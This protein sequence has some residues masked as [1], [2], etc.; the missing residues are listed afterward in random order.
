MVSMAAKGA[1]W[2]TVKL[3]GSQKSRHEKTARVSVTFSSVAALSPG[4]LVQA[5]WF[6]PK[7]PPLMA[8]LIFSGFRFT[9][10][11]FIPMTTPA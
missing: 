1:R 9:C 6:L 11:L 4:L 8:A 5:G 7:I 2:L 3:L 10:P